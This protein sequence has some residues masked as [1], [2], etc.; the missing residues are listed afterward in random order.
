MSEKITIISGQFIT[1]K[2]DQLVQ[3]EKPLRLSGMR[4]LS[5]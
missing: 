1:V 4:I 5:I 3:E 2:Q